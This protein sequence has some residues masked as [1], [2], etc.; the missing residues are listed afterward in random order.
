M[1]N[2]LANKITFVFLLLVLITFLT[3]VFIILYQFRNIDISGE[4]GEAL[5]NVIYGGLVIFLAIIILTIV[6]GRILVFAISK[7]L[8]RLILETQQIAVGNYDGEVSI[9]T[10][11]EIEMLA[12]S[13]NTMASTI[14]N[15][16]NQLKNQRDAL[17]A[18]LENIPGNILIVDSDF[19]IMAANG[20][21]GCFYRGLDKLSSG[22]EDDQKCFERFY[23]RMSPCDKC[24][25]VKMSDGSIVDNLE[26]AVD[27]EIYHMRVETI[28]DEKIG[29][30]I[31]VY[32]TKVTEQVF[33][34][35]EVIQM[36]KLA[37][38]G[39]LAAGIVHELK[40][41]MAVLKAGVYYLEQIN[42]EEVPRYILTAESKHTLESMRESLQRAEDSVYN[43]LDFSKP[44]N[45]KKENVVIEK[46]IQQV[47]LLFSKEIIKCKVKVKLEVKETMSIGKYDSN[48]LKNAFIHLVSNGLEAMPDGGELKIR[49]YNLDSQ[50]V[51]VDVEDEGTGI[52]DEQIEN[53]FEPFFSLKGEKGTGLGLWISKTQ[54]ERV[55]VKISVK[56]EIGKG[57]IFSLIFPI[58]KE[59][60]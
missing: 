39:Q 14:R 17:R 18:I 49:V 8:E 7:P 48:I 41:P 54:L 22:L 32:S 35:K 50:N 40:N 53:V 36:D 30:Q 51:C 43:I 4:Y 47:M 11:D 2:S 6:L 42:K 34:E 46:L 3:S 21:Q 27:E 45:I 9:K 55:G 60:G 31:L 44:K 25:I 13:I 58:I 59:E 15:Y 19:K 12:D 5:E 56:S 16:T 26:I 29:T 33:M 57:T 20:N 23:N 1:K 10:N 28:Y 37:Q 24:P 38:M 52:S